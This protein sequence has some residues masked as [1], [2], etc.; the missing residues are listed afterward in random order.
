[1]I[2]TYRTY[3]PNLLPQGTRV[4]LKALGGDSQEAR[5]IT[6]VSWWGMDEEK[7]TYRIAYGREDKILMVE[8]KDIIPCE[9]QR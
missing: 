9:K 5:V 4:K 1:M 2:S 8:R 3:H 7:H 6:P